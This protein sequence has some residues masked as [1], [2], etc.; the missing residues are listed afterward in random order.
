MNA[1][2]RT[3]LILL[4][5]FLAGVATGLLLPWS[6]SQPG[7]R[8]EKGARLMM[9]RMLERMD[10]DFELTADQRNRIEA[11]V[12]D[13]TARLD[14]LRQDAFKSGAAAILEMNTKIE[15]LLTPEQRAKFVQM[16]REQVERMRRH[17]PGRE[18]FGPRREGPPPPAGA[19]PPGPPPGD[20]Q[21]EP[22]PPPPRE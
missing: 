19:F 2:P 1:K 3:I 7:K 22:P 8:P 4:G 18:P 5:I 20:P 12:R 6:G 13:S 15:A 16:Q 11:I 14:A 21:P 10:H 17:Q 9:T